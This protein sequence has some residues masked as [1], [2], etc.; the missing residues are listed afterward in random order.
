MDDA[1]WEH[2]WRT[3]HSA[4]LAAQRFCNRLGGMACHLSHW[5][6]F[7]CIVVP[8]HQHRDQDTRG[9]QAEDH[10]RDRRCA[11]TIRSIVTIQ[12]RWCGACTI[13]GERNGW[14]NRIARFVGLDPCRPDQHEV[15]RRG[16]QSGRCPETGTRGNCCWRS[17]CTTRS[18]NSLCESARPSARRMDDHE[19]YPGHGVETGVS[20]TGESARASPVLPAR[21]ALGAQED[22]VGDLAR[23]PARHP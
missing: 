6:S 4:P 3:T 14:S 7:R 13:R 11:G 12:A 20:R 19:G 10:H 15:S 9:H 18:R 1:L 8:P 17:M 21:S 22:R 2:G 23:G 16:E 5:D